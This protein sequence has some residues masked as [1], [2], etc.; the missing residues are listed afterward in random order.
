MIIYTPA[1]SLPYH[2]FIFSDGQPHF[3][4][5]AAPAAE[6]GFRNATIEARLASFNDVGEVLLAHDALRRFGF[7][8][9]LDIRYLLGARMDRA[10]SATEPFTLDVVARVING[11]SFRRVRI[12]DPH[13]AVATQLIHN[14]VGVYPTEIVKAVRNT[15]GPH[16][17]VAPDKGSITRLERDLKEYPLIHAD[18][19]RDPSTGKITGMALH[20][21]VDLTGTTCLIVDDICDGGATFINLATLLKGRGAKAVHLFVTHGIFSKGLKVLLDGGIDRIFTTDSFAP[22]HRTSPDVTT[23]EVSMKELP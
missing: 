10:L 9:D 21:V 16:E 1:G 23:F 5:D 3:R 20:N 7:M 13:S 18:K 4:L 2:H 6:A 19:T 8:V 11:S 22:W 15:I 17:L 14:S 12:L